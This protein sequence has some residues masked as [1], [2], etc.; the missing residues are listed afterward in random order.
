MRDPVVMFKGK[1]ASG[2]EN[3]GSAKNQ[4]QVATVHTI[5]LKPIKKPIASLTVHTTSGLFVHSCSRWMRIYNHPSAFGLIFE[6]AIGQQR[7]TTSLCNPL[8]TILQI[9]VYSIVV[10]CTISTK[11]M[12]SR[13]NFTIHRVLNYFSDYW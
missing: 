11:A 8:L 10:S 9:S 1:K 6:G 3:Q 7:Q 2:F 13:H 12:V 5:C 4:Q